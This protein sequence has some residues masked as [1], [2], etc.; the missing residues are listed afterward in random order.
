[1]IGSG[2]MTG[3]IFHFQV[4]G[5]TSAGGPSVGVF[6]IEGAYD[7]V[8]LGGAGIASLYNE[9]PGVTA[10]ITAL[11]P[12][13]CRTVTIPYGKEAGGSS[14]FEDLLGPGWAQ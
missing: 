1:M 2:H 6:T 9:L 14:P 8:V 13:D 11:A 3:N 10:P 7:V 5:G 12:V 4:T